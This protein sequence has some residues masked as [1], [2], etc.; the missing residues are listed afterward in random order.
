MIKLCK[1]HGNTQFKL[2]SDNKYQCLLC[3]SEAVKR[4]RR[5]LKLLA[6]EYK[7][8]KCEKCDYSKSINALHFHHLDPNEKDFGIG[9]DGITISWDKVKEELDKCILVCANC[10][11]EIHENILQ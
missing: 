1:I 9:Q 3:A 2:R 8:G 5:K 7:C 6:V 11:A 4:R 10:H